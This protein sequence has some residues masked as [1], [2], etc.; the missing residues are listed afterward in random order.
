MIHPN[1]ATMIAVLMTD[2]LVE[3][4]PLDQML[5]KAVDKSFHRITVDGDTS[6]NDSVFALASG[7]ACAF[8]IDALAPAFESVSRELAK[9]I[10]RDAEGA[11]KLIHVKISGA[12]TAADALQVAHTIAS[13]LLVRTS[14]A[15]GD[16]NWGRIL[17][18]AGRSGVLI[19]P[20][21]F[22]LRVNDLLV[23]TNGAPSSTPESQVAAA[24]ATA[25]IVLDIDLGLGSASDEFMTCDLTEQYVRI[26]ADYTT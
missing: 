13:S 2:A 26:N 5:R 22:T 4:Q 21:K 14:I 3:P 15:G 19:D 20:D 16:P 17:A 9:K 18:A 1:M 25:E 7:A 23:F 10:L 24:Y 8:P 12:R 11:T 6:T